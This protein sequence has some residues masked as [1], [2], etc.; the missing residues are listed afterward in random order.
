MQIDPVVQWI[1]NWVKVS[2]DYWRIPVLN[3]NEIEYAILYHFL[4]FNV[5]KIDIEA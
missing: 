4:E 3:Q 2:I 5:R 1:P